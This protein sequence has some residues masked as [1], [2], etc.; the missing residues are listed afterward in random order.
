MVK[1]LFYCITK[2]SVLNLPRNYD[3]HKLVQ[4]VSLT[5]LNIIKKIDLV[6]LVT[7]LHL[8]QKCHHTFVILKLLKYKL[9]ISYGTG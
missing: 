2:S 1:L 4:F 5:N 8:S 3:F 9:T 6:G 7:K